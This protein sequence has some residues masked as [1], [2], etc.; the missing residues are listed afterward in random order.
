MSVNRL[1][2]IWWYVQQIY[3]GFKR[4]TWPEDKYSKNKSD[5]NHYESKLTCPYMNMWCSFTSGEK[6]LISRVLNNPR[7]ILD[8]RKK[9]NAAAGSIWNVNLP[10]TSEN[11]IK[12]KNNKRESYQKDRNKQLTPTICDVNNIGKLF[13][14]PMK[15]PSDWLLILMEP[16]PSILFDNHTIIRKSRF[17]RK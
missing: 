6:F 16:V 4:S 2:T 11:P 9:H 10:Q 14:F 8:N 13:I 17:L 3:F 12:I 5:S 7:R 1:Y 15:P